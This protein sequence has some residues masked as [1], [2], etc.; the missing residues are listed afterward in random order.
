MRWIV[1]LLLLIGV[2]SAQSQQ[3]TPRG[4]EQPPPEKSQPGA[5]NDQRGTYELPFI[6]KVVPTQTDEAKASEET[7]ERNQKSE[8]DRKLVD[9]NG[10]LAF[11]TK[12]LAAFAFLQFLA[13]L[14]Q[15]YWLGRTVKVSERA[16]KFA[17]ESADAV[18][19]QL[20]AYIHV[21]L[22]ELPTIDAARVLKV[23]VGVK[24]MGQTPAYNTVIVS[25]IGIIK[26]APA[27]TAGNYIHR[28]SV[29][30]RR[31]NYDPT[32]QRPL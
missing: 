17:E 22:M 3:S 18:V 19:G 9:F 14:I 7:K 1:A 20:R 13:M 2:A 30:N 31:E 6:V 15:A 23:P 24:N 16:A 28:H 26:L 5:A 27:K 29:D 4:K 21:N 8:L 25:N 10:D 11:Y 12:F 32:R